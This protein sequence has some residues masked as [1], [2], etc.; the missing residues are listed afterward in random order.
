[1]VF[2]TGDALVPQDTN[3]VYDVY[4]YDADTGKIA[5]LSSG[6]GDSGSWFAGMSAN[7]SDVFLLTR[8]SLVGGDTDTLVDLYD[9]RVDGGLVEPSRGG[10]CEGEACQGEPGIAPALAGPS[11]YSG[12]GNPAAGAPVKAR[13]KSKPRKHPRK[14]RKHRRKR[15]KRSGKHASGRTGHR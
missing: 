7:G 3:G 8:Q 11:H 4:E 2:A 9:A 5:L 10:V 14:K 13:A 1:V 6:T 12:P 15:T